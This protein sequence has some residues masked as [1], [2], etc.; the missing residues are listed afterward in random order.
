MGDEIGGFSRR[1]KGKGVEGRARVLQLCL[2]GSGEPCMFLKQEYD[3]KLES[4]LFGVSVRRERRT[5]DPMLK[6]WGGCH[7]N[8]G[9]R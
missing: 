9:E 1:Q 4:S 5:Q 3:V 2:V 7:N 6:P 8:P